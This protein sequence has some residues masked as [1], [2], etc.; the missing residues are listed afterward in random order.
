MGRHVPTLSE[1]IANFG[2]KEFVLTALAAAIIVIAR[3]EKR[4]FRRKKN[5]TS[6]DRPQT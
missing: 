2:L 6:H 5:D 3:E 1:F 4:I